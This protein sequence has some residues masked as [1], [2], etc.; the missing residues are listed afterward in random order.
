MKKIALLIV[1]LI[2]SL[3]HCQ[4]LDPVASQ[5]G[6]ELIEA[7]LYVGEDALGYKYFIKNSTLFKL[8]NGETYQ[9][10]NIYLGKISKVAIQ[11]SLKIIVF[12]ESF[13]TVVILDSVLN[14]MQKIDFSIHKQNIIASA[15]GMSSHNNL[16][17]FNSA[18]QQIGLYDYLKKEYKNIATPINGTF[19]YYQSNTNNFFWIDENNNAYACDVYGKIMDLGHVP[20]FDIIQLVSSLSVVYKKD[21]LLYYYV[22]NGDKNIII[23]L[24]EK[25]YLSFYY[26]DQNLSIFTNEG[27]TKY[28]INLP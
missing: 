6:L 18:N 23:N 26:I 11:N 5:M 22:L 20:D 25:S 15:A 13:N 9:Y 17:V 12:Y 24:A 16:W 10:K 3:A 8:K 19:K 21:N 7:D 27:I 28:Q 14:E 1:F 2:S 4:Y